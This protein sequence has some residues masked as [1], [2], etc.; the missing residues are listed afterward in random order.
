MTSAAAFIAGD[1]GTSNLRLALCDRD[2]RPLDTRKGPGAADSRGRFAE[3]FDTLN[4]EWRSAHGELPLLM[5]G[6]AGSAFGWLEAPYLPSPTELYELADALVQPRPGVSIVP[7]VRLHQSAGR[8]RRDAWRRNTAAG[9]AGRR[10]RAGT[11]H[12]K[13]TGLH[14][15]THTKWVALHGGVMQEF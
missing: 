3:V 2:G 1:W 13:A 12:G 11:G 9:C 6:M 10:A 4:S 7:G 5:C 8:S 14:A 15:G